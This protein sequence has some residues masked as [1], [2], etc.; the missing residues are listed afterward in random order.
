MNSGLVNMLGFFRSGPKTRSQENALFSP[1]KISN[2]EEDSLRTQVT[3]VINKLRTPINGKSETN[4]DDGVCMSL[5]ADSGYDD[6]QVQSYC[7]SIADSIVTRSHLRSSNEPQ[8]VSA[9]FTLELREENNEGSVPEPVVT[10]AATED[11]EHNQQSD[12]RTENIESTQKQ[13][14]ESAE[15]DMDC[16]VIPESDIPDVPENITSVNEETKEPVP[17]EVSTQYVHVGN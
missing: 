17:A 16:N 3:D 13:S 10:E 12:P 11:V 9:E 15:E 5:N 7:D 14:T 2:Y 6:R 4:D 8:Q 1:M